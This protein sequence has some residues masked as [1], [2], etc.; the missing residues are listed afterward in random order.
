MKM[1]RYGFQLLGGTTMAVAVALL[2]LAGGQTMASADETA[3][4]SGQAELALPPPA[5]DQTRAMLAF[6][7]A[8]AVGI[9]CASAGYAVAKV[10]AA[11]LGAASE[12]PEIIGRALAFVGLAE[13]VA[14]FG[15]IIAIIIA[16][17]I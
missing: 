17:K 11:A 14:V 1:M 9:A 13:G 2:L 10:G 6:A 4:A 7:A 8:L 12:K 5:T 3:I 16:T 15:L